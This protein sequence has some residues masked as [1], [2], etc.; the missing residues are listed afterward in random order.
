MAKFT[1]PKKTVPTIRTSLRIPALMRD[2][3]HQHMETE[4]YNQKQRNIWITEAIESLLQRSD[5]PNL[6]AEEFIQAGST[7][8]IPLTLSGSLNDQINTALTTIEDQEGI[9]KDRSA[10]LRTAIIQRMLANQNM[11]L[12]EKGLA[13]LKNV[14]EGES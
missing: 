14:E 8:P 5:F 3:L 2:K 6:V 4:G 9:S 7:V 11:Q 1:L 10:L 13:S 12:S